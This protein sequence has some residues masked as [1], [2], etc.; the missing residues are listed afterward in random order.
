MLLTIWRNSLRESRGRISGDESSS[1]TRV[2]EWLKPFPGFFHVENQSLYPVCKE[3]LDFLGLQ[4]LAECSGLSR[5]QVVNILK[6]V[7]AR[8][9][10]SLHFNVCAALIIYTT[11]LVQ[12]EFPDMKDK[13]EEVMLG[14]APITRETEVSSTYVLLECVTEK[15]TKKTLSIHRLCRSRVMEFFSRSP[16]GEYFVSLVLF[17]CLLPTVGFHVLSRTAHTDVVGS[18]WL[19][20]NNVLHT[21]GHIKYQELYLFYAFFRAIMPRVASMTF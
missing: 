17:I 21:A 20:L 1:R 11:D 14:R 6:H 18:F 2:H 9:N 19:R 13:I 5:S 16:N 10:H 3:M 8:N 12:A 7:H 15:V 4:E